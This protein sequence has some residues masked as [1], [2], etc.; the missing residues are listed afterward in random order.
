MS[1]PTAFQSLI[2]LSLFIIM[3]LLLISICYHYAFYRLLQ[4]TFLWDSMGAR[5]RSLGSSRQ[6]QLQ[7]GFGDVPGHLWKTWRIE[8]RM[9][10]G[11]GCLDCGKWAGHFGAFP[12]SILW[13]DPV[14][15]DTQN[16]SSGHQGMLWYFQASTHWG[17]RHICISQWCESWCSAGNGRGPIPTRWPYC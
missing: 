10:P 8:A 2:L 12:I 4:C 6:S 9:H 16:E 7:E 17:V 5:R 13:R 14:A 11:W 3:L 1:C 15:C